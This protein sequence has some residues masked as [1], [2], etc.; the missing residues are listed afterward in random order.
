[1]NTTSHIGVSIEVIPEGGETVSCLME[2]TDEQYRCQEMISSARMP[3]TAGQGATAQRLGVSS[4]HVHDVLGNLNGNTRW[5][6]DG[7]ELELM[8]K[9]GLNMG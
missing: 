6:N 1:M 2:I 5:A 9:D 8:D 4:E 3:F 7:S